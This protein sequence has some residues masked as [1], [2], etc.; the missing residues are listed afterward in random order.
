MDFTSNLSRDE[1]V[2]MVNKA[3]EYIYAGDIIQ[4]VLSQRFSA[5]T[6]IPPLQIYRALR[7]LNPS[8]YTFFLK[9]GAES[10]V[11]YA[12]LDIPGLDWAIVATIRKY[13]ASGV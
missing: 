7:L 3:K 1:Y 4:A 10:L 2:G 6:D 5:E 9:I 11:A 8:P 12:P 13:L